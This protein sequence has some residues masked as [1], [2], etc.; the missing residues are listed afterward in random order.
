MKRTCKNCKVEFNLTGNTRGMFCS[1]VCYHQYRKTAKNEY[2]IAEYLTLTCGTCGKV[3]DRLKSQVHRT[4]ALS[5]CSPVCAGKSSGGKSSKIPRQPAIEKKC[6][7][8][9]KPY[10]ARASRPN[11]KYCSR[12]CMYKSKSTILAG[13]NNPNYRHG[14]NLTS[15]RYTANL[16]YERKCIICG[17]DIV[18]QIHHIIGRAKGGTNDAA[19]LAVLCPNHHAMAE[20]GLI[21][22]HELQSIVNSLLVPSEGVT[23]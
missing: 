15:G 9:G 21:Q 2:R 6:D 4:S 7:M 19:N 1:R 8:C 16:H 20:L 22:P 11:R 18:V 13:V 3:F 17:F 10:M 5:F 14:K 23:E 12:E